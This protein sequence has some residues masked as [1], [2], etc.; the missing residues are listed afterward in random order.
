MIIPL[1]VPVA[2]SEYPELAF[3]LGNTYEFKITDLNILLEINGTDFM[4]KD[5]ELELLRIFGIFNNTIDPG[6]PFTVTVKSIQKEN[7]SDFISSL[8]GPIYTV[9]VTQT[10]GNVTNDLMT[11]TDMWV[12]QYIMMGF[13]TSLGFDITTPDSTDFS[14]PSPTSSSEEYL[15]P[16]VFVGT[17][18]TF[19]EEMANET[20]ESYPKTN[21]SI[22]DGIK[23][24]W[25][26]DAGVTLIDDLFSMFYQ[27]N[28]TKE[29]DTLNG[30]WK[31]VLTADF[32]ITADLSRN[33]MTR[34][35]YSLFDNITLGNA[36]RM[37]LTTY[38]FE[39][40]LDE[41]IPSTP[42]TTPEITTTQMADT[43]AI[44]ATIM[45]TTITTSIR[46]TTTQTTSETQES[47]P[48]ASQPEIGSFPEVLVIVSI[49]GLSVILK[50]KKGEKIK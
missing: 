46:N 44:I 1:I 26:M 42:L 38:G 16:S 2:S 5:M 24:T 48:E 47:Q 28:G 11:M 34:F 12:W 13:V 25:E 33:L 3:N 20:S 35:Y 14:E 17:N 18:R 40:Y 39:E 37:A 9:N 49:L 45:P 6:D 7:E 36:T 4:N 19:Y 15:G 30:Y 32:N 50:R 43:S 8:L 29:T 41:P 23:C 21:T 31:C 27:F 10:M 22:D